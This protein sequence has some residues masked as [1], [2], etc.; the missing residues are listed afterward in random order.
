MSPDQQQQ[1]D[2]YN[3]TGDANGNPVVKR[4]NAA[5]GFTFYPVTGGITVY[6][7]NSVDPGTAAT[8]LQSFQDYINGISYVGADQ[9]DAQSLSDH[10]A[11]ANAAI[12][13]AGSSLAPAD[14]VS[15]ADAVGRDFVASQGG[16]L[17]WPE[18]LL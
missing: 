11:A 5:G 4:I 9:D 15:A 17:L 8:I 10:I 3:V 18:R 2:V 6:N 13:V 14:I 12:Q 7:I 1:L 16:R